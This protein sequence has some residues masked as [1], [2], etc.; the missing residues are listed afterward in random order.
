MLQSAFG[1]T[2]ALRAT[3]PN[4]G[5]E[6]TPPSIRGASGQLST[7]AMIAFQCAHCRAFGRATIYL[8][9]VPRLGRTVLGGFYAM[10]KSEN[11]FDQCVFGGR[12]INTGNK[13]AAAGVGDVVR[14]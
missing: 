9:L 14:G 4:L 12:L 8:L 3:P 10:R 5:G 2:P 7:N 1:T 6:P 13:G 11:I